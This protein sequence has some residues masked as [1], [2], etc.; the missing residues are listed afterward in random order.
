MI[1]KNL[2]D[3]ARID[4][5][6]PKSIYIKDNLLTSDINKIKQHIL[7]IN[8]HN[9][10][11]RTDDL[12][13]NST[14]S[15]FNLIKDKKFDLFK[16]TFLENAIIFAKELGYNNE[17]CKKIYLSNMWFNISNTNDYL[18]KHI[19]PNSSL[20]GV[21]YIESDIED[22]IKFYNNESMI[23]SEDQFNDLSYQYCNYECKIGRLL[24]FKSDIFHSTNKAK[25]RKIILSFNFNFNEDEI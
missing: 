15:I 2:K 6:F 4:L 7:D 23:K 14:H 25:S 11:K 17:T 24:L 1:Q 3:G 8:N 18:M 10:L 16:K 21:F 22:K 13:V 19:H 9:V 20:S 5:W 12:Q